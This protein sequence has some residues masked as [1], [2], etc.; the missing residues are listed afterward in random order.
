MAAAKEESE[1]EEDEQS[2][3]EYCYVCQDGG[4]MMCCEDC[5]KVAHYACAGFKVQPKGDWWCKDC[6]EKKASA[7]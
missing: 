6:A 7:A 5:P 1:S 2:W 3:E 4:N